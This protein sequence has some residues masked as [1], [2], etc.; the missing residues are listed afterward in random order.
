[1]RAVIQRV[2]QASVEVAGTQISH[3]DRGLLV[4]LGVTLAD[5]PRQADWMVDKILALRIFANAA[6]KLDASVSDIGGEV[7]IVSQFTLYAD[8][9]KGRRPS[10][11][12]AAP[13]AHAE[14]LYRQ[15]VDAVAARGLRTGAGQFGADMLVHLVNDGPLTIILDSAAG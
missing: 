13:P 11:T 9:R 6:G 1:M 12:D 4:L 5:G 10:F 8:T 14:P 15:V 2:R 3:I 7:L